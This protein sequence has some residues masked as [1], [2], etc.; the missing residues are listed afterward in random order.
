[1]PAE[2]E[3]PALLFLSTSRAL[4]IP[5]T[6]LLNIHSELVILFLVKSCFVSS[7]VFVSQT[8]TRA[9]VWPIS[10]CHRQ[11]LPES[12][13]LTLLNTEHSLTFFFLPPGLHRKSTSKGGTCPNWTKSNVI[14]QNGQILC[15]FKYQE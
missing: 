1:M 3:T 6:S 9:E 2:L 10:H 8:L 7:N 15:N 5:A 4:T 13:E 12:L 11:R 14:F